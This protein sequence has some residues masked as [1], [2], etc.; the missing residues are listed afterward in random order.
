MAK[1]ALI[2]GVGGTGK[3]ALTVLKERLEETYGAVPDSVNLLCFDTDHLRAMDEFA[4]TQ[5]NMQVDATRGRESEFQQVISP[6]GITMNQVFDDLRGGKTTA[7]MNWLEHAKLDRIL[8]A[9]DRTIIGG[10][11]QRR[12]IGRTALFLRYAPIMTSLSAAIGKMYGEAGSEAGSVSQQEEERSRRLIFIVSSVA[13]GTG[14]GMFLDIANL[15]RAALERNSWTSVSMSAVIVLPDAFSGLIQQMKDPTNLKPNSYAALRELDRF[16]RAHSRELPYPIR[17]YSDTQSHTKCGVQLFDHV[18]LVDT[19]SRSGV[20]AFDLGRDPQLGVFPAMADFLAAHVDD[21]LGDAIAT[22]RSNAGLHYFK[23]DGRLYS[24]FNV[25]TYIFPV[26]DVVE[27]FSY[28]FLRDELLA[29]YFLPPADTRKAAELQRTAQEA[30]ATQMSAATVA[31]KSNTHLLPGILA[32]TRRVDPTPIRTDWESFLSLLSLSEEAFAADEKY[33]RDTLQYLKTQLVPT[34]Q[35]GR[36]ESFAQGYERLQNLGR[37]FDDRY[38]GLKTDSDREET[39][40]G[41]EWDQILDRYLDAHRQRFLELLDGWLLAT[42]N[43]RGEGDLLLES[44]VAYAEQFL[45]ALRDRVRSFRNLLMSRWQEQQ[46]DE[47]RRR[48]NS[49][50]MK[51]LAAMDRTKRSRYFPPLATKPLEAQQSYVNAKLQQA[52]A[53]LQARLYR[54]VLEV[55]DTIAG[56]LD[57]RKRPS[58]AN[59]ALQQVAQWRTTMSEVDGLLKER[60]RKHESDREKKARVTVRRYASNPE[61]EEA[62]Y[63]V[64]VEGVRKAVLGVTPETQLKGLNWARLTADTALDYEVQTWLR[65]RA[66]GTREIAGKWFAG[67][68]QLFGELRNGAT[69]AERLAAEIGNPS[70]F[71]GDCQGILGEPLLRYNPSLNAYHPQKETYVFLNVGERANDRTRSFF[72]RAGNSFGNAQPKVEYSDRSESLVSCT[73]L[74]IARGFKLEGVEQFNGEWSTEYRNKLASGF[75]SIHIFPEEQNATEYERRLETL[76]EAT[77]RLRSFAPELVVTMGSEV[78]LRAFAKATAYGL[79]QPGEYEDPETGEGRT[80]IY[81][82]MSNNGTEQKYLLSQSTRIGELETNFTTLTAEPKRARL[83]LNA[84]QNFVVR[85]A[86]V[87]NPTARIDILQVNAAVKRKE[88]SLVVDGGDAAAHRRYRIAF[89]KDFIERQRAENE[90]VPNEPKAWWSGALQV[91]K[92]SPDPKIKDMGALLHLLLR[93]EIERLQAAG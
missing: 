93:E 34:P 21:A 26:D 22:Q 16:M 78:W 56:D 69:V 74:L 44:R 31:E 14:S 48:T 82:T 18:Y 32:A 86:D 6:A 43:G 45:L 55:C 41:G 71:V 15:V 67:V 36:G 30:V 49:D 89:L 83:F 57:S 79:I 68:K 88:T 7:F 65:E 76:Q 80:E 38:M 77:Q 81:L 28:R 19:T 63:R 70:K 40:A 13:G 85:Q 33:L 87:Y 11:Q 10:A 64:Y 92:A 5:L 72:Q 39:R 46:S 62:L 91:M 84:L 58:I 12:P 61:V 24:S 23:P 37:D 53:S 4:G 60:Q 1:R 3:T 75:E 27:S 51:A 20:G 2:I 52:E 66:M 59:L 54:E 42:L 90:I 25:L 50:V 8:S 35:S 9:E 47:K 29:D 17:Y 73:V